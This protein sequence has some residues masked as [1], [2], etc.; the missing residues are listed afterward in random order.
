MLSRHIPNCGAISRSGGRERRNSVDD[1]F[2]SWHAAAD[3]DVSEICRDRPLVE[4]VAALTRMKR[5]YPKSR[6]PRWTDCDATMAEHSRRSRLFQ[7][8]RRSRSLHR[9]A[10]APLHRKLGN[11]SAGVGARLTT[12]RFLRPPGWALTRSGARLMPCKRRVRRPVEISCTHFRYGER[13]P[14]KHLQ[15]GP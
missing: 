7:G 6:R 4:A 11:S 14:V 1:L 5:R 12:K 15:L 10:L 13:E 2:S 9:S 8:S 3:R